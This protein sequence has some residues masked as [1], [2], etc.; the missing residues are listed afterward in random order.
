MDIDLTTN[1]SALTTNSVLYKLYKVLANKYNVEN[2]RKY[3]L[4][5]IKECKT[6]C[7]VETI[8]EVVTKK[9]QKSPTATKAPTSKG[10]RGRAT[11]EVGDELADLL[12]KV[13]LTEKPPSPMQVE[14]KVRPRSVKVIRKKIIPKPLVTITKPLEGS[15]TKNSSSDSQTRRKMTTAQRAEKRATAKEADKLAD[16]F[17]GL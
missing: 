15:P 10:K 7:T 8:V 14:K 16:L 3:G 12:S 13:G 4:E 11:K 17:K 2:I 5:A 1:I 9:L 6:N